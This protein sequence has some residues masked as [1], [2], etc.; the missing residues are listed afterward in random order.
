VDFPVKAE[1]RAALITGGGG[2]IGRALTK[3]LAVGG[4][5]C[6]I[7]GR[8]PKTLEETVDFVADAPGDVI[9]C[10]GDVT[11]PEDRKRAVHTCIEA[12]TSLDILVN[13]AGYSSAHP[14]LRYPLETWRQEMA[15]NLEAVAFLIREV[16]PFMFDRRWG[17]IVNIGSVY[18]SLALNNRFYRTKWPTGDP[19]G[20]YRAL[21]YSASKGGVVAVTR[22]F[23]AAVG[24][25]GITV[26]VVSPGMI[27]TDARPI[28]PDRDSEFSEMTP[29]GRVG[30]PEDVAHAVAFLASDKASFIT[31]HELVVDGG[32]SIW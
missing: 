25:R 27:Q 32:W 12:F 8:T 22:D 21:A 18:G 6:C 28:E 13:N 23:A 4:V 5:N 15:A 16:L 10:R 3:V 1:T 30:S 20:P 17:R 11:D 31:G 2:A 14:L 24:K 19:D 29:V 9:P 7:M 26:N